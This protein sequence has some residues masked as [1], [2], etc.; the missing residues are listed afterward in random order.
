MTQSNFDIPEELKSALSD[1]AKTDHYKNYSKYLENA[2]DK[3]IR[4]SYAINYYKRFGISEDIN[5]YYFVRGLAEGIK[6]IKD[7]FNLKVKEHNYSYLKKTH[8]KKFK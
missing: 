7:Y 8:K 2:H 1:M 3:M 6:Y 4:D 5:G